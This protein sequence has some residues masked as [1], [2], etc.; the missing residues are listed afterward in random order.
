[1]KKILFCNNLLGGLLLFRKNVIDHFLSKGYEVVLVVIKGDVASPNVE[2]L[3]SGVKV[4]SIDV[5]RTSTNPFNDLRFF[6]RLFNIIRAEKPNYVFNY[7]IKPNIYG[8]MACKLIGIPC[9]NMMAGL[10]YTF[11]NNSFSSRIARALYKLGL[12]CAQHLFLLNEEN[13]KELSRLRLCNE[14]K[15][16]WL[17]GGEGV[18]VNHYRYFDN[19]SEEI[20]FL[21]IGRLIEEKGYREFV[22][23]AKMVLQK[24]PNVQFHIVGEY[25]LSYPKA[26]SKEE[27]TADT[28]EANIDY[29]GVYKDMMELYKQPGYVVCIPSYYSEG[30]NR[31]LM[32]GCAVGKPIITTNHPGC[33]EMVVDGENGFVVETRNVEALVRAMEKYILLSE[34]DKRKMSQRSRSLAEQNFDVRDVIAQYEK[35]VR[36][37]LN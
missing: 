32:E 19:S 21:F 33:R 15:I 4:Y 12:S 31:S 27:V 8:A 28:K 24:Y 7:T 37:A 34:E 23:A 1:M 26:V 25:D 13:V 11:T 18:D 5:S 9:T 6:L 36:A 35:L 16:I 2:T 10:G 14:K 22:K 29:L 20:C 17:K 3:E 30:L